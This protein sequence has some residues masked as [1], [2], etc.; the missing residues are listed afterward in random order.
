MLTDNV[1]W[2]KR[3]T[4]KNVEWQ[5]TSKGQNIDSAGWLWAILVGYFN[6]YLMALQIYTKLEQDS[7]NH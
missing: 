4:G 1:E 3:L 7:G 5:K 6:M 2:D